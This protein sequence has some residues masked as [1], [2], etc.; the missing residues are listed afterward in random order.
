M[1]V[2]G[3]RFLRLPINGTGSAV[4]CIVLM[5]LTNSI[6]AGYQV[7]THRLLEPARRPLASRYP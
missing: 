7:I 1:K 3:V 5:R 2:Y 4:A 6:L